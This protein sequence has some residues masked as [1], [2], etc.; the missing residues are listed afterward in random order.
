VHF[1]EPVPRAWRVVSI[2]AAVCVVAGLGDLGDSSL[3]AGI[4]IAIGIGLA[5]GV[6]AR[7]AYKRTR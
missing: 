7:L 5:I 3:I 2:V 6:L 4:M 1:G